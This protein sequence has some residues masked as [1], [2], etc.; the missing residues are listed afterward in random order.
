MRGQFVR[1]EHCP[2]Q[3]NNNVWNDQDEWNVNC[4]SCSMFPGIQGIM[5]MN[6]I[7]LLYMAMKCT[8]MHVAK[9]NES[10][11]EHVHVRQCRWG[12]LQPY[13]SY[14]QLLSHKCINQNISRLFLIKNLFH[15][16]TCQLRSQF[17]DHWVIIVTTYFAKLTSISEKI[18]DAMCQK[19]DPPTSMAIL[20]GWSRSSGFVPFTLIII[21]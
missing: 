19:L 18:L 2:V 8:D 3:G 6:H 7:L 1:K 16:P 15:V 5:I 17:L 14:L 13:S 21:P 12:I 11:L 9:I 20:T 4:L 10:I